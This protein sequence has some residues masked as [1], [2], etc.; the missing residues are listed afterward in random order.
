MKKI[1][2]TITISLLISGCNTKSQNRESRI[3]LPNYN[4]S[5]SGKLRYERKLKRVQKED[6]S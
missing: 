1:L 6:K 4:H 3:L 2:I 5:M